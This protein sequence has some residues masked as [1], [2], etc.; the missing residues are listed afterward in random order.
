MRAT[1]LRTIL[2]AEA[3]PVPFSRASSADGSNAGSL[4]GLRILVRTVIIG[5]ERWG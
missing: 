4:P 5:S 3:G 1:T 2:A